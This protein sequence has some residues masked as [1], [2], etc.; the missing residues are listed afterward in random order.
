[1]Q[2]AA[3]DITED[4]VTDT[5]GG[6]ALLNYAYTRNYH[7]VYFMAISIARKYPSGGNIVV[8]AYYETVTSKGLGSAEED[9]KT[10]KI[11]QIFQ[12]LFFAL[13]EFFGP[14]KNKNMVSF[15][16]FFLKKTEMRRQS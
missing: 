6:V 14:V 13:A 9:F 12:D 4:S 16:C 10:K 11:F 8:L 1:L 15:L 5:R 3:A 7:T 2:I